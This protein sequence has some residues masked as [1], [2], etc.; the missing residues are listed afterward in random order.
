LGKVSLT[1]FQPEIITV[2]GLPRAKGSK[3][4]IALMNLKGIILRPINKGKK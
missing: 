3:K 2:T 1:A 4:P